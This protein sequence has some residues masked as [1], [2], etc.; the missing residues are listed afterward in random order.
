MVARYPELIARWAQSEIDLAARVARQP[1]A[2]GLNAMLLH[3]PLHPLLAHP[4]ALRPQLPPDARPAVR[5]A[6]L[7]I[8]GADVNQKCFLYPS[9]VVEIFG[10]EQ[11][12]LDQLR[13]YLY[14]V[15]EGVPAERYWTPWCRNREP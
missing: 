7:R 3:Q 11:A 15:G 8:D 12:M 5:P 6:I 9:Q 4:N 1:V 13:E 14:L 10:D 2:A